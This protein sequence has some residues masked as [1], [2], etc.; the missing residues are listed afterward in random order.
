MIRWQPGYVYPPVW[1]PPHY[2]LDSLHALF[3]LAI[4]V[5]VG[6]LAYRRPSLGIGALIVC[7]PFAEARYIFDTS[8][9]V[10]KAAL[11]G[12]IVALLVHRA[13]LRVLG[14][15]PVRAILLA[16]AGVLTAIVLSALHAAHLDAVAREFLK[17]IE[18][19]AVFAAVVVGFAFDPDDR[20]IWTAL[21]A[22]GLF[23]VAAAVYELLFGASSGVIIAGHDI[24]R[25]AG[26]LEGP[27]Q[28]AG[29]LNLLLPVLFA[30][31]LDR[32]QSV[33]RSRRSPCAR[34]P[35]WLR[36]RARGSSLPSSAVVVVLFVT[37]P[38]RRVGFELCGRSRSRHRRSWSVL[39]LAFGV[40]ARFFSVAEVPQPDHLGTRA[41]LWAAAIDLWRTSPLVGIGAGNFEFDLGLVGHPEV[42][43]H[44]NSLYL[45]ALSETGLV[46]LRSDVV[47][48]LERDRDLRAVVLAPAAVDRRFRRQHCARAASGVR[49]PVVF[50]EGRHLLG[51]SAGD[52]R[53][54]SAGCARRCRPR[55]GGGMKHIA[56]I[57]AGY[58][59]L[60]TGTCFAEL[61]E[62][63][64]CLD[65]NEAKIR[66]LDLGR[67]PFYEPQLEEMIARNKRA[68][69]LAF[70]TDVAAGIRGAEVIFIAVDTPMS[71]DGMSDLSAVRAV[72]AAIGRALNGPKVVVSKS[73]V[74]VETADLI[75]SII[76]ENSSEH[77]RVHVVSNPE[78][79]REG[80]AIAD[81]MRPDR[82]V[83]GTNSNE[84]ETLMR[85]LY[86]SFE[87]PIVVTDVR[88]SEMIKLAA[89]A[90]LATKISFM[91]EIA[92]ICDLVDVD[93]KDVGRGMGFDHRIGTQFMNPGIGFGGSCLPKDLRALEEIAA[94]RHYEAP[95]L[96]AVERIN[97]RQIDATFVKIVA[98]LGGEVRE[99]IVGVLGLAFKPDTDDIR[100]SPAIALIERLF[101]AGA[102]I[103]AHDPAAGAAVQARFGE[104]IVRCAGLHEA[105]RGSDALVLATEW[106]EYK[107]IDFVRVRKL[108]R[109]ATVIDGRNAFDPEAVVAA[110]LDYIGV[111][112]RKRTAKQSPPTV[113]KSP[114]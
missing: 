5:V 72:A 51:D 20:P 56:V 12:F 9:T 53:R 99:K 42:R 68:G 104:R 97:R 23:E 84:A 46:G 93:V 73:T 75:A 15:K 80:S 50:S 102:T 10:P 14:E 106:N 95:L 114:T 45:Q 4:A 30:R 67:A 48:D 36:S 44:A 2:A 8:I 112:R 7:A 87:A 107:N 55:T 6:L 21:I 96:R 31:M 29:W 19:A 74:P 61:G 49:L 83:I 32:S 28:F 110:G 92:N 98:A 82:I 78:F 66:A 77:H 89:N 17:W 24:P 47:P 65:N 60:V 27:N 52:R 86:R 88:T 25:V 85:D 64:V 58:V 16:F 109:G 90:F 37:R 35:R 34:S 71:G 81:F 94:R 40:E 41:I 3:Y 18:Y 79:L 91:N 43:T 38:D 76:A 111:G 54:G 108:M 26:T 33:A 70:S 69:R 13:S 39:G 22:I 11:F 101:A 62:D 100:G 103:R 1:E 63:V 113:S 59:G 105:L 57:G